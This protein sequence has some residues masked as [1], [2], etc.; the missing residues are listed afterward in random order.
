MAS[1]RTTATLLSVP[2]ISDMQHGQYGWLSRSESSDGPRDEFGTCC[3]W[4]G[5]GGSTHRHLNRS[6]G[7]WGRAQPS[8]E[9][10]EAPEAPGAPGQGSPPVSSE[11]G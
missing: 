3:H 2:A 7:R 6:V 1:R 5:E 10:P 9:A 11:M 8:H 4:L